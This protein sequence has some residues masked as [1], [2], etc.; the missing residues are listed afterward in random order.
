MVLNQRDVSYNLLCHNKKFEI[1]AGVY[2][3][4]N[5]IIYPNNSAVP[6][7]HIGTDS[8]ALHCHTNEEGH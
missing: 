6:L 4:L 7:S 5:G 1:H 8:S 2:F 3:E